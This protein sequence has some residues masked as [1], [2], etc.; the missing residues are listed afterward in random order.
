MP[1]D[2]QIEPRQRL[3]DA[4]IDSLMSVELK[5]RLEASLERPLRSTLIFDYPTTEAL[6]NYLAELLNLT[7]E[8]V[9]LT[10]ESDD[11]IAMLL[12]KELAEI[13]KGK[14]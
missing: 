7:Q 14:I 11:D 10:V 2:D 4:G 5:N 3:F 13:Q 9:P 12:E 8:Q 1:T 6:T